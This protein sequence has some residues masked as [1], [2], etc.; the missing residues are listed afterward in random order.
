MFKR[1]VVAIDGSKL[2]LE[3]LDKAVELRAMTDAELYLI[4]V[5]KHHSLFQASLS[6]E[7]PPNVQIAD[8]ALSQFAKEV[9]EDAKNRA[10]EHGATK[11]RG[12]VRSGKP[13]KEIVKFAQD[14]GAD[15]IV[16]GAH[17]TN[18]DTEGMFLGS[19]SHR[20]ASTAK[21]PTLVI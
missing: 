16:I 8:D 21:C 1:I 4:C 9:V 2:A 7:R 13:S 15:L 17:G 18:S 6:I 5:Y 11:V 3:A 14:K 10:R 19:V 20:V 12:F